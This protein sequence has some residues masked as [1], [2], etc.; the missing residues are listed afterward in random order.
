MVWTRCGANATSGRCCGSNTPSARRHLPN[1]PAPILQ[2]TKLAGGAS[3]LTVLKTEITSDTVCGEITAD[4]RKFQNNLF[5]KLVTDGWRLRWAGDQM[6]MKVEPPENHSFLRGRSTASDD[7]VERLR[8]RA[9]RHDPICNEAADEI[10]RLRIEIANL[11]NDGT[12]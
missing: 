1:A 12:T 3:F 6:G 5:D 7:I 11:P 8:R 2:A 9:S 10:E 4:I